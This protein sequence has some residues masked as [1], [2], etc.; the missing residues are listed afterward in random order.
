MK[1]IYVTAILFCFVMKAR[2]SI[3][4]VISMSVLEVEFVK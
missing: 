4:T 3:D 2:I 1:S